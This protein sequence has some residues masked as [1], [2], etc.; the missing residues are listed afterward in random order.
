MENA[1]RDAELQLKTITT[2]ALGMENELL[3]SSLQQFFIY[4]RR[5]NSHTLIFF[6]TIHVSLGC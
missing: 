6:L 1:Q 5:S 2:C 3:P 4:I